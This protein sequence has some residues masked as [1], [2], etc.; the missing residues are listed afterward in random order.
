MGADTRLPIKYTI[1]GGYRY[2]IQEDAKGNP[3]QDVTAIVIYKGQQDW[4]QLDIGA[5]YK[6]K[7]VMFGVWYR[8]IP[9]LKQYKPGYSNN[10]AIVLMLGLQVHDFFHMGY[11]YDVTISKLGIGSKGS[12]ELSLIYEFA[13]PEYK[14][15]GKKQNFMVPCTKF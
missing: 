15:N 11:S 9:G 6:Y 1:Q 13:Q 4:D 14:R 3:E 12:H 2:M 8:G 10:D 7:M 5:Y